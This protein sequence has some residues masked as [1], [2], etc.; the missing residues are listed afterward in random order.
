MDPD[1]DLMAKCLA[2]RL[3]PSRAFAISSLRPGLFSI[4]AISKM[5]SGEIV[6]IVL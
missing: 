6:N 2:A 5:I 1:T 3:R 4:A